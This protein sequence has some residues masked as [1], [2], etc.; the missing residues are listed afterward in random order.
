M[1]QLFLSFKDSETNT[2]V[3]D[4]KLNL[5]EVGFSKI[6]PNV[7][8]DKDYLCVLP[9]ET[10]KTMLHYHKYLGNKDVFFETPEFL[11][12]RFNYS[13]GIPRLLLTNYY[14]D[15][16][17]I[18]NEFPF[19]FHFLEHKNEILKLLDQIKT[20]GLFNYVP[21]LTFNGGHISKLVYHVAISKFFIQN[22]KMILTPEQKEIIIKIHNC[23]MTWD[24][25]LQRVEL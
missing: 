7:A 14:L 21:G 3:F 4:T 19:E 13:L 5:Y 17:I 12:K 20:G 9:D 15:A 1:K 24:E 16:D 8:K 22:D 10:G 18:G 25:Y 11:Y 2:T 23:Q 6:E